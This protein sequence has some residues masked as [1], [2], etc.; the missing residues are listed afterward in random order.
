M[1][2]IQS[3]MGSLFE[4][5]AQQNTDQALPDEDFAQTTS[6]FNAKTTGIHR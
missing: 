6:N 4:L 5:Q 2:E 1:Q 3:I